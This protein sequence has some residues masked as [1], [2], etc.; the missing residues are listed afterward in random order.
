MKK[1]QTTIKSRAKIVNTAFALE[2]TAPCQLGCK[3]GNYHLC[4]DFLQRGSSYVNLNWNSVTESKRFYHVPA[5][6]EETERMITNV[7]CEHSRACEHC[8]FFTSTSRDK[9]FALRA[10]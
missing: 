1:V 6:G 2:F 10:V 8:D 4:I 5:W 3:C 7:L 9:K